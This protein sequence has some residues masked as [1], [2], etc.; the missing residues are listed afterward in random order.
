[1]NKLRRSCFILLLLGALLLPHPT[2]AADA[3]PIQR[4]NGVYTLNGATSGSDVTAQGLGSFTFD[5]LTATVTGTMQIQYSQPVPWCENTHICSPS[6]LSGSYMVDENG[7]VSINFPG[8]G[9]DFTGVIGAITPDGVA[10]TIS[11][12]A[13]SSWQGA[14]V[15]GMFIRQEL[16]SVGSQGP[17]GLQG[18]TGATGATGL[19]G[20]S[21]TPALMINGNATTVGCT[22]TSAET[23]C[24]NTTDTASAIA[25]DTV[26]IRVTSTAATTTRHSWAVGADF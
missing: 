20:A 4:V 18:A 26:G 11:F 12:V 22:I 5:P 24:N 2:T 19:T 16:D 13:A 14:V 15:V 17:A 21:G 7:T 25:G 1:M 10:N 6:P 23:T 3:P 8:T 9:I